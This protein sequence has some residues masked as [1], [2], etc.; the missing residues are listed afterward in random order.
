MEIHQ[1]ARVL[2]GQVEAGKQLEYELEPKRA[3]WVHVVRGEASV[4]G[5]K[6]ATGDAAAV[7]EEEEVAIQGEAA[8]SEV[9]VFDL[10]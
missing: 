3:A 10:A 9:L 6:L 4:N 5:K 7:T 1:D 2:L 8:N